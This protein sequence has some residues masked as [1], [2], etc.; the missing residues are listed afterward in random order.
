MRLCPRSSTVLHN[1]HIYICT[2]NIQFPIYVYIAQ[3]IIFYESN[4]VMECVLHVCIHY[5]SEADN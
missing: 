2:C 3:L 1:I 5:G 4:Y